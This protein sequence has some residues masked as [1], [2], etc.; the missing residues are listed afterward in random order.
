MKQKFPDVW[1]SALN[2][3]REATGGCDGFENPKNQ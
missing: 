2:E 1:A 3:K